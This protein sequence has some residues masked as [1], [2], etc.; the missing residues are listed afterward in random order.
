MNTH[1]LSKLALVAAIFATT[2][3]QAQTPAP[4]HWVPINLSAHDELV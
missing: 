4:A 1:S 2:I 3:A